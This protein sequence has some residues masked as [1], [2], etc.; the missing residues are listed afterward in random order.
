MKKIFLGTIFL[1]LLSSAYA[2]NVFSASVAPN[3]EFVS[4][5]SKTD[6]FH[7]LDIRIKFGFEY[8]YIMKN[9]LM[10][11]GL[12][13]LQPD[14]CY[15]TSTAFPGVSIEE[16]G[17]GFDIAPS[18]GYRFGHEHLFSL[19]LLPVLVSFTNF[20]GNATATAKSGNLTA[21]AEHPLNG[22][23][24]LFS[25]ELRG[26]IQFGNGLVRN[27]LLLGIGFPWRIN[28]DGFSELSAFEEDFSE[29]FK[30]DALNFTI[31]YKISFVM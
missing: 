25:T 5:S 14:M 19:E 26:N 1:L 29:S 2:E 17:F 7:F 23:K 13:S 9:G 24:T 31:G 27:S 22:N 10:F 8:N 4:F 16:S 20:S 12:F 18:I 3:F 15:L 28:I 11:G 30:C 6:D 21:T